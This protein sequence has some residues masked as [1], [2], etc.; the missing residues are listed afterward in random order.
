MLHD[1]VNRCDSI[2][3]IWVLNEVRGNSVRATSLRTLLFPLPATEIVWLPPSRWYHDYPLILQ[4]NAGGVWISVGGTN[5]FIREWW[6]QKKYL[7]QGLNEKSA[8]RP[9]QRASLALLGLQQL[10]YSLFQGWRREK[11]H[12][13]ATSCGNHFSSSDI[14]RLHDVFCCTLYQ[15]RTKSRPPLSSWTS[16]IGGLLRSWKIDLTASS[17]CEVS[18]WGWAG[19]RGT[20]FKRL[21]RVE[22]AVLFPWQARSFETD[23]YTSVWPYHWTFYHQ[24]YPVDLPRLLRL[25]VELI[26]VS[27]YAIAN[28]LICLLALNVS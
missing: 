17:R 7:L 15:P 8:E 23:I 13:V 14:N 1:P 18:L 20:W 9:T 4:S 2:Q 21:F 3:K 19:S 26:S 12:R 6:L 25:D 10:R 5:Q 28:I 16:Y 24:V 11:E 27:R 22:S